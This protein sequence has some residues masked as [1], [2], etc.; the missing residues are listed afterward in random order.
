VFI[1]EKDNIKDL[2]DTI[3]LYCTAST[4]KF[5]MTKTTCIPIGTKEYRENMLETRQINEQSTVP[6]EFKLLKEGE[7]VRLLGGWVGNNINQSAPWGAVLEKQQAI[8]KRWE[9]AHP[10]AKGKKIIIETLIYSLAQYLATVNGMPN[11]VERAMWKQI[12]DFIWDGKQRGMVN[13]NILKLAVE[14]GGLGIPDMK[15]RLEAIA[16]NW[17]KK[18]LS[19]PNKRPTWA[20]IADALMTKDIMN[21]RGPKVTNKIATNW[22][23]QTWDVKKGKHS[24]L[25][26]PLK[27]MINTAR[28]YNVTLDAPKITKETKTQLPAWIN[29]KQ[30]KTANQQLNKPAAVCLRERHN[31]KTVKDLFTETK[32]CNKKDACKKMKEKII[33]TVEPK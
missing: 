4:A 13:E 33:Q 20:Y 6:E 17:C 16:L 30:N 11:H 32:K 2:T 5:N 23:M 25:P 22:A 27:D 3:D 19:E 24:N 26:V 15:A 18:W 21:S 28:K 9:K 8:V 14:N 7:C 10:S 12:K 31:V 29:T 1:N